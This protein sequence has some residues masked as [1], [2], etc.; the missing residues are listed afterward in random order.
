MKVGPIPSSSPV[1]FLSGQGKTAISNNGRSPNSVRLPPLELGT[2]TS[3]KVGR[4]NWK[5]GSSVWGGIRGII[6]LA[7]S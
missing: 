2:V 5:K 4:I 7:S 3:E 6:G 1:F